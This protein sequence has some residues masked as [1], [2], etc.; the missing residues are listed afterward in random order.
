MIYF[1]NAHSKTCFK[2]R[3]VKNK[4]KN[5]TLRSQ[6]QL[7]KEETVGYSFI[8]TLLDQKYIVYK[9]Y[10]MYVLLK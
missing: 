1:F 8:W 2:Y 4:S 7:Q 10:N 3:K 5:V 6:P 9:L